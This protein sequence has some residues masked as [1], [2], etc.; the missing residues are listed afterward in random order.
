MAVRNGDAG[1]AAVWL[2]RRRRW[3][4]WRRV[5]LHHLGRILLWPEK[6][7][8]VEPLSTASN[9]ASTKKTRRDA[10]SLKLHRARKHRAVA[11]FE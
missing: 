1:V 2:R 3:R 8:N 4:R 5:L 10:I 7:P 9:A 11:S 6:R